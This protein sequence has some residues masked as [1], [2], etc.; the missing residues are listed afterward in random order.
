M[1]CCRACN[2]GRGARVPS[3][4]TA[5][6]RHSTRQVRL[7]MH[8]L[9]LGKLPIQPALWAST[10][11]LQESQAQLAAGCP[12]DCPDIHRQSCRSHPHSA[13]TGAGVQALKLHR[14]AQA[15]QRRPPVLGR[16]PSLQQACQRLQQVT[17]SHQP[18]P[19]HRSSSSSR[20]QR[21]SSGS[22]RQ[23]G[24]GQ[25]SC[26]GAA[27]KHQPHAATTSAWLAGAA[28]MLGEAA[29]LHGSLGTGGSRDRPLPLQ[30]S[31]SR[32]LSD[33]AGLSYGRGERCG[34][35]L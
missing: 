12:Y 20:R 7:H 25:S 14:L 28:R 15:Q 31:C 35:V 13:E 18:R 10:G 26:R 6:S 1:Q 33:D 29:M 23:P 30:T 27:R 22:R 17:L 9:V 2:A 3:E 24:S 19:A 32:A 34:V 4:L 8:G 16:H 5:P 11:G 21:S